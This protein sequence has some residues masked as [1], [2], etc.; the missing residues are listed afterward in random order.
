MMWKVVV[1]AM[2]GILALVVLGFRAGLVS[3]KGAL[4]VGGTDLA[5][6]IVLILYVLQPWKWTFYSATAKRN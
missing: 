5:A 3:A 4:V 1:F 2:L 6:M